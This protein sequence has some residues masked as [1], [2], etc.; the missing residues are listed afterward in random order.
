M[1]EFWHCHKPH[2]HEHQDPESLA[3]K[4]Y[5]ANHAI[6]AQQ[7]TGFVD[8]TSFLFSESDCQGLKYSSSNID[9]G[10]DLS[11]LALNEDDTKKFLHIFCRKCATE[12]GLYNIAALSVTLFKW[13]ISCRT[14]TPDPKPSSPEC[15][16][17]TLLATIS[18]SGSSKS[19]ITPHVLGPV[20]SG[21]VAIKQ[22]L[23]LWVLNPNVVY[24][25]SSTTGRKTAMKILYK[26]IDSAEGDKLIT[27][28]TSDVQ[29]I[30]LPEAAIKAAEESLLSSS[31][32]L[33][34]QERT[35]KEWNVGLLGRW[36][37]SS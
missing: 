21:P 15:L 11:S 25:A 17:A 27:S 10:F 22:N 8:L 6:S 19:I 20:K 34:A 4:G 13:R 35:F 14:N 28:M 36:E 18:R 33:P 24:T 23:H 12:V 7:G 26:H 16:A 1:M 31:Q 5:G 2:D 30:T 32:L 3:S 9:A 37:P 29:E